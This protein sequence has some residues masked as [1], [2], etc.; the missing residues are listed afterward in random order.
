MARSIT[1][2]QA[3]PGNDPR[4][5]WFY[6][7]FNPCK[8]ETIRSAGCASWRGRAAQLSRKSVI[9]RI[10]IASADVGFEYP[11]LPYPPDRVFGQVTGAFLSDNPNIDYR[12]LSDCRL[13]KQPRHVVR[14]LDVTQQLL[15]VSLRKQWFRSLLEER[16]FSLSPFT[17]F[18]WYWRWNWSFHDF[19]RN[20]LH[21]GSA[22]GSHKLPME[23]YP[24][25]DFGGRAWPLIGFP[26]SN[27]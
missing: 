1:W 2:Q 25:L 4:R 15:A 11:M 24:T 19:E 3:A 23:L 10:P 26:N 8:N 17:W 14:L 7:L 12:P 13:E 20:R 21:D 22:E 9:D 16:P 27:R 6:R 18:R 5:V